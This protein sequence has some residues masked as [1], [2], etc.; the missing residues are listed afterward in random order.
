[1]NKSEK[2]IIEWNMNNL[3]FLHSFILHDIFVEQVKA[4]MT[5]RAQN[6]VA[7]IELK[8]LFKQDFITDPILRQ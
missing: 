1:M 3:Y 5:E 7:A 6:L 4:G 2:E 8:K